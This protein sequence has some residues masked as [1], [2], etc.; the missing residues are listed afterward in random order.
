MRAWQCAATESC[1]LRMACCNRE[2]CWSSGVMRV[3]FAH[4][5][6]APLYICRLN[7][8]PNR[9]KFSHAH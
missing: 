1:T 6:I 2:E 4:Y 9:Q 7:C 5:S 8:A 3:Y